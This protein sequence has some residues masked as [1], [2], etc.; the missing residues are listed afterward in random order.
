VSAYV[1][2]LKRAHKAATTTH[3][4]AP[5]VSGGLS[6]ATSTVQ[7]NRIASDDY[8]NGMYSRGFQP[9][10]NGIG[11]H[12]YPKGS[13]DPAANMD[14][15]PHYGIDTLDAIRKQHNDPHPFWITEAGVSSVPCSVP[16]CS[17]SQD[18][19]AGVDGEAAQGQALADMY[20]SLAS[21]PVSAFIVYDFEAT[22]AANSA[23]QGYGVIDTSSGSIVPKQSYCV[24]G[25]QIGNGNPG[26][27]C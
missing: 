13:I 4:A 8:L 6:P 21:R 1:E 11:I 27:G 16:D 26:Y 20:N 5:V 17:G 19:R 2:L 15:A 23:F 3:F 18:P 10:V 7:G 25:A 22:D 14:T 9:Y 24:L 12:P